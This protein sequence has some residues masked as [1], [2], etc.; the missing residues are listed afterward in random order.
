[1]AQ[2]SGVFEGGVPPS[3]AELL[4][5]VTVVAGLVVRHGLCEMRVADVETEANGVEVTDAC[6][7]DEMGGCGEVILEI[8]EQ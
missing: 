5:S 3:L 2:A 4:A 6:D 7:L 1:M 8:F